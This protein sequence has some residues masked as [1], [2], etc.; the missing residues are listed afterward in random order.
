MTFRRIFL[1]FIFLL[2]VAPLFSFASQGDSSSAVK[3]N[4]NP[5]ID[6]NEMMLL[7]A[8]LDLNQALLAGVKASLDTLGH[9]MKMNH[10]P[11]DTAEKLKVMKR[12]REQREMRTYLDYMRDSL[13][14]DCN[15]IIE[16]KQSV[17]NRLNAAL[18]QSA[19]SA[20]PPMQPEQKN[21]TPPDANKVA[22]TATVV[23]QPL[24]A[25]SKPNVI[26][27][28]P[29][30]SIVTA[31][32]Q[33]LPVASEP[34]AAK[35]SRRKE[36]AP[37]EDTSTPEPDMTV[38]KGKPDNAASDNDSIAHMKSN[39]YYTL[40][41]K[42]MLEKDYQ[43]ASEQLKA[44]LDLWKGNFDA[45]FA[46]ASADE[47]LGNIEN[48]LSDYKQCLT[49]HSTMPK[50]Y[51]NMAI[52]NLEQGD[53]DAGLKDLN[54][55]I[56]LD[57]RYIAA[58]MKRGSLYNDTA[59]YDAAIADYNY[60]L[61]LNLNY[62]QAYKARGYSKLMERKFKEAMDDFTRYIIYDQSDAEVYYYRGLAK[63]GDNDW[64]DGCMELSM[65]ANMGYSAAA[66]AQKK[67]CE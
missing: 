27:V 63:I 57:P 39:Y 15:K 33:P 52:L 17:Q 11:K 1:F 4:Y 65:S 58:Y 48:A 28:P 49:I 64:L 56:Q 19:V 50:V 13:T 40:A 10:P 55:A 7:D 60:V 45:W 66:V 20:K 51:Y 30:D 14:R 2:S 41:Q 18:A 37:V 47:Q 53:K 35:K 29:P 42:S 16:E 54:E 34:K 9:E 23:A 44:A 67:N 32:N 46:L 6:K 61:K 12:E 24:G 26:P 21:I 43:M 8:E 62:Y 5:E 38:A 3:S 59:N 31:V 36:K 25:S 22:P